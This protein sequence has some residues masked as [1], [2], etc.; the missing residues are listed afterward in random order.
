MPR[1]PPTERITAGTVRMVELDQ[2]VFDLTDGRV[3]LI[4]FAAD[5]LGR[6]GA[7]R[8]GSI[9][10]ACDRRVWPHPAVSAEKKRT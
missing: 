7:S 3:S 2:H 5:Q 1:K 9:G 4:H 6:P 8:Q 10:D